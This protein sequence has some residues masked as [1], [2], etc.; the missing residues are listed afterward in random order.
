MATKKVRNRCCE[1]VLSTSPSTPMALCSRDCTPC[2]V[3]H[4]SLSM[5]LIIYGTY[6]V[7]IIERQINTYRHRYMQSCWELCVYTMKFIC[8]KVGNMLCENGS[9]QQVTHSLMYYS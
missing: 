6:I 3:T 1:G 9:R 2:L 4:T 8:N 7:L 5:C